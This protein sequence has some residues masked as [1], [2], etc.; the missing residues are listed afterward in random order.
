MHPDVDS[1]DD[2]NLVYYDCDPKVFRNLLNY[3]RYGREALPDDDYQSELVLRE[4]DNFDVKLDVAD[5]NLYGR[6]N[7]LRAKRTMRSPDR[8]F[9][10]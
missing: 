10:Q 1:L 4:A 3:L 5:V 2:S 9:V 6:K 8:L 7:S